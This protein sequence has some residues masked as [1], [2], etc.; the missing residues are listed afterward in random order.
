MPSAKSLTEDSKSSGRSF[1]YIRKS[2]VSKI[3]CCGTPARTDDQ[4]EHRWPL[5]A[6]LWNLLFKKLLR[7]LG[8]FLILFQYVQVWIL[9]SHSI[10]YQMILHI[11]DICSHFEGRILIKTTL[12]CH[13]QW[14]V[15][16]FNMSLVNKIQI[17]MDIE[18]LA[19]DWKYVFQ[20][21]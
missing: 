7:R 2:N 4:F 18:I 15:T 19:L 20:N 11:Q 13:E 17:S 6:T 21:F 10:L 1:I 9:T 3:Q 5:S 8:D 14:I 12:E 16:G